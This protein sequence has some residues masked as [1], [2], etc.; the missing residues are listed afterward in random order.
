MTEDVLAAPDKFEAHQLYSTADEDDDDEDEDDVPCLV[1][2]QPRSRRYEN[3]LTTSHVL[4][5]PSLLS[6]LLSSYIA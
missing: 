5:P 2:N 6:N 4:Y 3:F 1:P